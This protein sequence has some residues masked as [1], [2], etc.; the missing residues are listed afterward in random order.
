[1]AFHFHL[2]AAVLVLMFAAAVAQ[3]LGSTLPYWVSVTLS[4]TPNG[5][6]CIIKDP[7]YTGT[8]YSGLVISP[9]IC[10]KSSNCIL[11]F[12]VMFSFIVAAA[13]AQLISAIT[14]AHALYKNKVARCQ[15][16]WLLGLQF[17]AFVGDAISFGYWCY[18]SS[19]QLRSSS[20]RWNCAG[21]AFYTFI[22]GWC[23]TILCLFILWATTHELYKLEYESPKVLPVRRG[24][25]EPPAALPALP[26]PYTPP[27]TPPYRQSPPQYTPSPKVPVY[28]PPPPVRTSVPKAAPAPPVAP[29][30]HRTA[31][32]QSLFTQHNSG[33]SYYA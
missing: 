25:K 20:M 4:R 2:W 13:V 26:P 30:Q 10:A 23:A 12:S 31:S 8:Q 16:T 24:V 11:N 9:S 14:L 19:Y 32:L 17:F 21:F 29:P 1:M 18:Y 3:F 27:H 15:S 28:K 6:P 7:I 22:G 5:D 33:P